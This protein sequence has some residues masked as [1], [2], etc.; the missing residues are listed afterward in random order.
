[1]ATNNSTPLWL[2]LKTDYIDENFNKVFH[3]IHR[4]NTVEK[5]P[6][7]DITI[8]LLERR[9]DALVQEFQIQPLLQDEALIKDKERLTFIARLLGLYLLSVNNAAKNYRTAF[10][11]FAYTLAL[12]EP[13]N[14]SMNYVANALKFVFGTLPAKCILEWNDIDIFYP[15]IVAHKLNQAMSTKSVYTKGDCFE[16]MG[17]LQLSSKKLQIAAVNRIA[18]NQ[19]FSSSL[20]IVEDII[21]V[22][23]PKSE[24]LKQSQSSSIENI[25]E[26]TAQFLAD[27]RKVSKKLKKYNIG[28]E[29]VVRLVSKRDNHLQVVS[30]NREFQQ[31][32]GEIVFNKNFFFYNEQD[33]I[34]AL[35]IDDEFEAVYK[36]EGIFDIKDTFLAYTK[37][38]LFGYG[39]IVGAKAVLMHKDRIG[40]G[41]ES[42]FSVYTSFVEGINQGDCAELKLKQLVLDQEGKPTGWI[43]AEFER[44]IDEDIDYDKAKYETISEGFVYEKEEDS[45]KLTVILTAQLVKAI[46]RLLVFSQQYCVSNPTDRYKILCI[47]QMFA[48]L[49][50]KEDD[51]AYIE[52][53]AE[54]LENLVRFAK[55]EYDDIEVPSMAMEQKTDGIVRREQIISILKAYGSP[56]NAEILDDI[57]DNNEHPLLIKIAT[58]VQSC[59]RLE[60]VINRS[61]QNVIKREIITSLSVETEGDADLEEDNGIYLGIESNR[62]E[63]KTSFFH[64]PQT[65]KEQRQ[66]I[67]VFKGVC[68][69]L[70]TTDGGTLY[71]GVND[72]GYVQG[73]E[74]DIAYLQTITCGNYKSIDGYMRYITD[75]AKQFFDIDVVANMKIRPMY[76]NNVLALEIAPYEFGIVKL[77]DIAYLR[78]NAESVMISESAIQRISSR[79]KLTAVTKNSTIE[80]L[81]KA[82]HAQYCVVLHNYQSSNSGN[83]RNRRVEVF[84]FTENGSSIWCYDLEKNEVRLFNIARIGYVE[85]TKQPWANEEKHKCGNIDVFNMTGNKAID[86]CLRLN[87]RAKNL[88]IEEFPRAKDCIV[89]ECND[90]SWLLTTKVYNIAGVARFYMGL[91][92]SIQIVSAPELKEYVKEF[93]SNHL[94]KL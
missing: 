83:I 22:I 42:G 6:F 59:N 17:T 58:L 86:V 36:G 48:T 90:N 32:E 73:I 10:I 15:D 2:D 61:M 5:D 4:N 45:A 24:K 77:E 20:A 62:Q 65:A 67:N 53:L 21:Q 89:K 11:L 63:F 13:K 50:G 54:Y 14:I 39:D 82:I 3:Y 57:I 88:L 76:D 18:V 55:S 23:T 60:D 85:A 28:S 29:V 35:N 87:L 46:Y 66:Y 27:Q 9:I 84:D 68:A 1:M 33:F 43:N 49:I 91:A 64:A 92:N 56:A 44:V 37:E 34:D 25:K 41:T 31:I 74:S 26:F 72:L 71:L 16:M 12:L 47:S 30:T 79:K 38:Y 51:V 40:W 81:S 8:D 80:E 75:Q 94:V 69:F 70:N 19:S 7:Y 78:V 93:C 52:F